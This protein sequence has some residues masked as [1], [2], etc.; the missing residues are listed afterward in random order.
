MAHVWELTVAFVLL[1]ALAAAHQG[2]LLA[3]LKSLMKELGKGRKAGVE[4][5]LTGQCGWQASDCP[6]DVGTDFLFVP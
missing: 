5:G 3:P 2:L 4:S 1:T 6:K